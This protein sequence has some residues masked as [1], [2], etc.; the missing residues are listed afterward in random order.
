M[1]LMMMRLGAAKYADFIR[2][3]PVGRIVV[4]KGDDGRT[5]RGNEPVKGRDGV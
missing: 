1:L 3:C 5:E 4:L 2:P